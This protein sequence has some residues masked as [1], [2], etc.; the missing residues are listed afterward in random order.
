[1]AKAKRATDLLAMKPRPYDC[2]EIYLPKKITYLS[3]LYK[4]LGNRLQDAVP[5][6]AMKIEGISVYEVDG[7]WR[8]KDLGQGSFS[9]ERTL[10]IR[11]LFERQKERAKSV[12][13][14]VAELGHDIATEIGIEEKELWICHY[15][16][17]VTILG[18]SN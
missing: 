1:M 10:V 12:E 4:Y 14:T 8:G 3:E 6:G 7:A 5:A 17:T 18:L 2:V 11:I 15:P 13:A 9:D 16:Q